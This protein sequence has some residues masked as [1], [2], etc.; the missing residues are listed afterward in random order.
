MYS[1]LVFRFVIEFIEYFFIFVDLKLKL[2]LT[3]KNKT[4][5]EMTPTENITKVNVK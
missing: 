5:S 3:R 2:F 4:N 1:F